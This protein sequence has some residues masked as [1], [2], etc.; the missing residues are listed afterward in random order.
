MYLQSC[1]IFALT[2][3]MVMAMMKRLV[4]GDDNLI[5]TQLLGAGHHSNDNPHDEMI[6]RMC[7]LES[8]LPCTLLT[9]HVMSTEFHW[10]RPI[11]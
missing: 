7:R 8:V 6:W 5:L 3:E 1:L 4:N 2:S 10:P 9:R 11:I